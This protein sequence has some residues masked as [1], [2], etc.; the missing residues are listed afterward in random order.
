MS[1]ITS[2]SR[3]ISNIANGAGSL[4]SGVDSATFAGAAANYVVGRYGPTVLNAAQTKLDQTV[5]SIADRITGNNSKGNNSGDNGSIG[6]NSNING[7]GSSGK[8]K[9]GRR[10]SKSSATGLGGSPNTSGVP[11]LSLDTGIDSG[12][13]VNPLQNTTENFTPLFIQ[14]GNFLPDLSEQP[15]SMTTGMLSSELFYKYSVIIQS[16]VNFSLARSFTKERFYDYILNISK[17]LQLYYMIDSII[18]FTTHTPNT[19]IAMTRL[20]MAITPEIANAHIKLREFLES[21]PI[22]P[23]LLTYIRH[24]YQNYAFS[25]VENSPIIRLSFQ[26]CLCTSEI[27]GSLNLDSSIYNEII[28]S[29]IDLSQIGSILKKIRSNWTVTMP[30]SSYEALYDPQF[31]TF[32]HNSCIAYEDYGSGKI[33]Y[34][35]TADDLHT[36]LY[37]GLFGNRLDGIIYASCSVAIANDVIQMGLWSPFIDFANRDSINSSLLQLSND[38]RIRPVTDVSFRFSSMVYS[39][40]YTR[41][42]SDNNPV[43]ELVKSSSAC[44]T[45]PQTHTLENVTQAITRAIVWLLVP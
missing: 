31:S 30:P 20:R 11:Q 6:N 35:I 28:E 3:G 24:M 27:D 19:N 37:Y 18:S 17:A 5:S 21:T 43:W 40:P 10:A 7:N 44:A 42:T 1:F 45:I 22:P 41:I 12:T 9:G 13:I 2:P 36:P 39:A 15:D 8:S 25:D 32:W 16:E 38:K 34:S 14:C 29:M 26:D 4:R 33:R 23:N